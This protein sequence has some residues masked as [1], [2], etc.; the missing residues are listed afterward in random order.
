MGKINKFLLMVIAMVGIMIA[1]VGIDMGVKHYNDQ[2]W[3]KERVA[4]YEQAYA[5]VADIQ[6]KIS[7]LAQD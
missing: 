1:A 2:K 3:E 5:D 7:Q 4:R 6:M